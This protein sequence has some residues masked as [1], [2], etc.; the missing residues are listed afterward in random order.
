MGPRAIPGTL[1]LLA[2]LNSF[3]DKVEIARSI[4]QHQ[5]EITSINL[6]AFGDGSSKGM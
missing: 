1:D 3:T 2:N 4:A 6:H 5:E